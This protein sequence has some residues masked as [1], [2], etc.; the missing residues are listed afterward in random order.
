M[1]AQKLGF[2]SSC[3]RCPS[4]STVELSQFK[5]HP[6]ISQGVCHVLYVLSLNVVWPSLT[7]SPLPGQRHGK[8]RDCLMAAK[9]LLLL[10]SVLSICISYSVAARQLA[11]VVAHN[12][13]CRSLDLGQTRL[14]QGNNKTISCPRRPAGS[15]T[16]LSNLV[17]LTYDVLSPK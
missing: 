6:C 15:L 10:P 1:D 3:R 4:I 11:R 16:S 5:K 2:L 8:L 14:Y 9:S 12:E 17:S 13:D 7:P